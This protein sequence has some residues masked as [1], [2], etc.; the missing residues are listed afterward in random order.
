MHQKCLVAVIGKVVASMC[1]CPPGAASP[2]GGEA[3]VRGLVFQSS[4]RKAGSR[5][6]GTGIVSEL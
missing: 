5:G 3:A 4:S 1:W 6:T 2:G